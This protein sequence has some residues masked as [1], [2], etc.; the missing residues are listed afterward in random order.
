MY[1]GIGKTTLANEICMK[2]ANEGFLADDFDAVLLISLR[3]VQNTSLQKMIK[4][5]SGEKNYQ[6]LKELGGEKCLLILEGLDEMPPDQQDDEFFGDLKDGHIFV[7]ATILITSR[8]HA[9]TQLPVDRKIEVIGFGKAEI[10]EFAKESLSDGMELKNFL[11]QLQDHSY[12]ISLCYVPLSLVMIVDLFK[13]EQSALPSTLTKLYQEFIVMI[14]LRSRYV[15]KTTFSI[16]A[17]NITEEQVY[18][19]LKG[20]PTEAV[21]TVCALS[22][23]AYYSF[24]RWCSGK[25]GYKSWGTK[26]EPKIIFTVEDLKQC[27]FQVTDEFDGFGL[28]KAT[29]IHEVAAKDNC[30]YN[31]VHFNIQEFLCALYIATLSAEEQLQIYKKHQ[32]H[33]SYHNIIALYCGVTRLSCEEVLKEV[34]IDLTEQDHCVAAR[35]FIYESQTGPPQ[36]AWL[37][38]FNNSIVPFLPYDILCISYVLSYYPVTK[39]DMQYSHL[40]D[41]QIEMLANHYEGNKVLKALDLSR[42]SLTHEGMKHVMRII[43]SKPLYNLVVN[44]ISCII[45]TGSPSLKRLDVN[46]NTICDEGMLVIAN[47]PQRNSALTELLL[48]NCNLSAKGTYLYSYNIIVV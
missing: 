28:L 10:E 46:Q 3:S 12:L 32:H 42:N 45:P 44:V 33:S 15:K 7:N 26:G 35:R 31:F 38:E 25:E 18:T 2:W 20:I 27:G 9:C 17:S 47:D 41:E 23:L 19:M 14:L 29:Y 36:S 8:P 22:K 30:V 48:G 37:F 24:F 11:C 5:E 21:K 40:D 4:K 34:F 13:D 43:A 1:T 6:K 39:L 16:A